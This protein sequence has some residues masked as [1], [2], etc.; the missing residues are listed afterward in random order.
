MRRRL[1]S[2]TRNAKHK[3]PSKPQDFPLRAL[4]HN[5]SASRNFEQTLALHD[6]QIVG[7]GMKRLHQQAAIAGFDVDVAQGSQRHPAAG[8]EMMQH[9]LSGAV[10]RQFLLKRPKYLGLDRL[11]LKVH[12]VSRPA[13]ALH[14]VA[15]LSFQSVRKE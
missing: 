5:D 12:L 15:A 6:R 14:A 13:A 4:K 2:Q 8:V 7:K 9:P 11:K 1:E 10:K 3:T